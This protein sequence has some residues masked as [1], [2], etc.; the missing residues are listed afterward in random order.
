MPFHNAYITRIVF[1]NRLAAAEWWF[2]THDVSHVY[3]SRARIA[4]IDLIERGQREHAY[5]VT[6]RVLC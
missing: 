1:F 3:V 2:V 6:L 4:R 5:G